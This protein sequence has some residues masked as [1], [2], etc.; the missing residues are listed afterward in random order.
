MRTATLF[1]TTAALLAACGPIG[2]EQGSGAGRG[3]PTDT[4]AATEEDTV[5]T[6][7]QPPTP[8]SDGPRRRLTGR[9]GGDAQL[10]GG[11]VWLEADGRRYEV[12]FP[13]GWRTSSQPVRLNGPSGAVA[14]EGD[15]VTVEGHDA[16]DTV[17]VCQVGPVFA[18][19][20]VLE[21]N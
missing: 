9:L 4:S 21:P 5:A 1:L 20:R 2:P 19:T 17:T 12:Q 6:P 16:P 8:A 3:S 13:P 7:G 14:E 11:C 18:A 15:R 10:E